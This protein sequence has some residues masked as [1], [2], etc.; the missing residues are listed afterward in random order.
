MRA[1]S[2]TVADSSTVERLL[3]MERPTLQA[4]AGYVARVV[5]GAQWSLTYAV[6]A[7]LENPRSAT[8]WLNVTDRDACRRSVWIPSVFSL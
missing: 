5:L 7:W 3:R 1:K 6:L 8:H 2:E 4:P